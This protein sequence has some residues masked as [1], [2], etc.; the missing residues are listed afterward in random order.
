MKRKIY[1]LAITLYLAIAGYSQFVPMPLNYN[2]PPHHYYPEWMSIVDASTV[3]LGTRAYNINGSQGPYSI[4]VHTT[5]GGNTW[6]FDTIPVTGTPYIRSLCAVD[7]NTC[8]Y[9]LSLGNTTNS[10]IWKTIDGGSS[11][12]K[13]NTTQFNGSGGF[14][15]F[16]HAFDA[17]EGVAVGDPTDG[18]F[19]IQR[20]TDGGETWTRVDENLIP[21]PLPGEWGFENVYCALEDNIWFAACKP[22]S[23]GAWALRVYRSDDRGQHWAVSPT[24]VDDFSYFDMDFSTAQKGVV[25]DP[26]MD[27]TTKYFYSTSDG[28]DSWTKDSIE[29]NILPIQGVSHVE[30]F[31]GGFIMGLADTTTFRASVIFTPDFFNTTVAIDSNLTA[32]P[33]GVH[34][35]DVSTGWISAFGPGSDT[36]AILKYTGLLT[37]ISNAAQSAEKLSIIPNPTFNEALVKLPEMDGKGELTLTIYNA[38]GTRLDNRRIESTTGWTKLNASTYNNGVY[39]LQIVSGDRLIASAKW[40]VQH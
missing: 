25:V 30:G 19:E 35:K 7:A 13:K 14:C 17:N 40:V 39:I 26:F 29:G 33:Y 9:V 36:S 6:Q 11:W 20:T 21:P 5:D 38:A 37:S 22:S 8:F 3:W 16:F 15:D 10:A 31:D 23:G 2:S 4:A 27:F 18:Y 28:G 32:D 34:F 1:M 24:V 12:V